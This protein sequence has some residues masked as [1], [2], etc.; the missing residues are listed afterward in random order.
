MSPPSRISLPLTFVTLS[1]PRSPA[2]SAGLPSLTP[3]T[4][5]PF[6]PSRPKPKAFAILG[7]ILLPIRP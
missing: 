5:N 7:V 2:L 1:P 6:A 4:R 3:M